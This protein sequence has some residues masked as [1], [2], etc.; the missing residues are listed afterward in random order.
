MFGFL[1][2]PQLKTIERVE[3]TADELSM[4]KLLGDEVT[5]LAKLPINLAGDILCADDEADFVDNQ[6]YFALL[7]IEAPG[8]AQRVSGT[9]VVIGRGQ[10]GNICSPSIEIRAL[11]LRVVWLGDDDIEEKA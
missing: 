9:A 5:A 10:G 8:Y 1:I 7:S 2:N 4:M 11:E 6:S 3:F